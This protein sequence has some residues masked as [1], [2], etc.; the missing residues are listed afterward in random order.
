MD[1]PEYMLQRAFRC[2]FGDSQGTCFTIDYKD[3][4]YIVTAQHLVE[5]IDGPAKIQIWQEERWKNCPINLVGHCQGDIDISVL[6][7]KKQLSPQ[8]R[9]SLGPAKLMLGQDAY[10][11][12]FP[13]GLGSEAGELNHKF[14]FPFVKKAVMSALDYEPS[15]YFLD[16]YI[17]GGF[18]GSPVVCLPREMQDGDC[19]VVAV[20]SGHKFEQQPVFVGNEPSSFHVRQ[21]T[22]IAVCYDIRYAVDLIDQNPI[23]FNLR[24]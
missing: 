2:S 19:S 20:V 6:A 10:I 21:N 11:L 24:D 18:S 4:Q 14:P 5:S 17:T 1:F 12:G 13:D 3:R 23:G 22:G 16:S 7:A 8:H 9:L 15:I